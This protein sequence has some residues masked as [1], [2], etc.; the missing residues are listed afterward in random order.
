MSGSSS[1]VS[2]IISDAFSLENSDGAETAGG[3]SVSESEKAASSI[4]EARFVSDVAS[5][6]QL[7]D[8]EEDQQR[9]EEEAKE[10]TSYVNANA[11]D[12]K[13]RQTNMTSAVGA[14]RFVGFQGYQP[15]I[16][17]LSNGSA[18]FR[19]RFYL[20]ALELC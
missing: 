4:T 8:N 12:T 9:L 3:A 17:N 18:T 10:A 15:N 14:E 13:G 16:I 5:Q 6:L 7:K 2:S 19:V 1:P 20:I 11:D